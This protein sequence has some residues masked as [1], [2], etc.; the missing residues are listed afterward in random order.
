MDGDAMAAGLARRLDHRLGRD[1]RRPPAGAVRRTLH[2]AALCPRP[3]HRRQLAGAPVARGATTNAITTCSAASD[4]RPW[5]S[6]GSCS[7]SSLSGSRAMG[8][9][10]RWSSPSTTRPPNGT[11]RRSRGPPCI[12]IPLPD[13]PDRSS[14][15]ATSGSLWPGCS[16]IRSG[17]RWPCRS[18]RMLYVRAKCR[19]DAG[20]CGWRFRTKLVLAAELVEWAA[21]LLKQNRPAVWVVVDGAYTKRPF[22]RP[23]IGAGVAVVGRLR[24]DAALGLPPW[25]IGARSGSGSAAGDTA[26][27]GS[28]WQARRRRSAAGRPS[29]ARCTASGGQEL[30]DVPGDLPT[31]RRAD[32]G[33]AGAGV[34]RWVAFFSTDPNMTSRRSW[35]RWP[36]ARRSSRTSTT[37]RRSWGRPA[38]GPQIWTNVGV[39]HLICGCT[40]W[41]NC[42]PGTGRTSRSVRPER[43]AVGR[44][45]RR[46]SHANRCAELRREALQEEY[47]S[48]P[49]VGGLHRKS[50]GSFRA[51]FPESHEADGSGK[52]QTLIRSPSNG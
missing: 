50:A 37:S 26:S 3:P 16:A 30:Q 42:G 18:W 35:R 32:P 33:G 17:E 27:T 1:A 9:A 23:V 28:A 4:A 29:C 15:T 13:R 11:G 48:L 7:A 52:V 8:R 47:S 34:R 51:S 43:L 21:K 45:E 39:Y 44:P 49:S 12:T 24:K 31:G 40:R 36:I 10:R 46:P 20:L 6:P 25:P 5:R 2:R 19:L 41:W 38:A 14:S 22:L